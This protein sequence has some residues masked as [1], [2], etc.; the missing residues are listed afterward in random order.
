[1]FK[2][3]ISTFLLLFCL[4]LSAQPEMTQ[5]QPGQTP[6]GVVYYLPKTALR[7][8]LTIEKQTYTPGQF[9]RYAERYLHLKGVAQQEQISQRIVNCEVSSFGVRDTS[10]CYSVRLKGK[11]ETAEVRLSEQ[12]TLLAVNDEPL[13]YS[14]PTLS[15]PLTS[16]L[17]PLTSHQSLLSSE[18]L[19]AGST[20]KMAE[21]TAQQIQELQ[22]R[23]QQLATGEADEM[24]QDE[25]QLRL[26]LQEID[27]KCSQ[28]MTHFTGTVR[29]DSSEHILTLCPDKEINHQ[30]LFRIS[31]RLGLVDKDDLSGIPYYIDLKNLSPAE[32]P[33][34]ENKKPVGFYVNVPGMAQL[35]ISQ[36]DQTLAQFQVPLA[37]FGFTELRDG[38]LFRRYVTHLQLHPATGAV[39][40]QQVEQEK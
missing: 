13:A 21:I 40:R 39:V 24:P 5:L 19:A 12:G 38:D 26:M 32:H 7:V 9:A 25:Q 33:V 28:L 34:P 15:A 18:A 10:K 8:H 2:F 16:H 27:R 6:D 3:Q 4:S 14:V 23:R 35:T 29:R 22:E 36:D 17:S 20:A 31:R 11:A 1:M 30:V 37:Q